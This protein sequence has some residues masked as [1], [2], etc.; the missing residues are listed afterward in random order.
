METIQRDYGPLG[1]QFYYIYKSLA[2]P[3]LYGYVTPFTLQE[4]LRHIEEARQKL[5]SEIEWLCDNMD[6]QIQASLGG[7][8]NSEFVIDPEGKI[9]R[10]QAWSDPTGLRR[11]LQER[12]GGVEQPTQVADLDMQIQLEPASGTIPTGIVP[13]LRLP[14]RMVPL[15]IQPQKDENDETPFYA[16]LRAEVEPRFFREGQGNLY[17]GFHLDRLYAVHWNNQTPPLEFEVETPPGVDITPAQGSGPRI[18]AVADKDPREF[19]LQLSSQDFEGPL[20][21]TVRYFACDDANTF[22]VPVTQSYLIQQERDP[23]GGQRRG[24]GPSRGRGDFRQRIWERDRNGD[25]LLERNELPRLLRD[26][27][28]RLDTNGDGFLDEAE[29]E[30]TFSRGGPPGF[31][32]PGRFMMRLWENDSDGDG[33]ISREEAPEFLRGRFPHLDLDGDGFIDREELEELGRRRGA[34]HRPRR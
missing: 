20:S 15:L 29:I 3:G 18:E 13:S 14:G 34:G 8:P 6:N 9:I 5:G 24:G 7:V 26:R 22:C 1:V 16:K 17:L 25:A 19:L 31:G 2:H 11:F 4:R 33:R 23:H 21:L 28:D 12:V 27:F 30:A 10:R 32:R